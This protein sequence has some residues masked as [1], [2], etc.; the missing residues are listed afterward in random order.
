MDI[1]DGRTNSPVATHRPGQ[2]SGDID[3]LS[4]RPSIVTALPKPR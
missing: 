4:G 1:V 2:F 3:V